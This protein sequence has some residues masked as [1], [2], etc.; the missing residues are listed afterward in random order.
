MYASGG[1]CP[2]Q[3]GFRSGGDSEVGNGKGF[4]LANPCVGAYAYALAAVVACL[5]DIPGL[6]GEGFGVDSRRLGVGGKGGAGEEGRSLVFAIEADG[7]IAGQVVTLGIFYRGPEVDGSRCCTV[8]AGHN[9][10]GCDTCR[11]CGLRQR[12]DGK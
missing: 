4:V 1:G 12:L 6:A 8:R 9:L 5:G 11:G 7:Y 3:C 2:C 10:E